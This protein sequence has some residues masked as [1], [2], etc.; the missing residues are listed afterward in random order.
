[1]VDTMGNG[2][3]LYEH[4]VPG[5]ME[6][7]PTQRQSGGAELRTLCAGGGNGEGN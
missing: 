5:Q 6:T 3:H 1:M 2:R 7:T 4:G